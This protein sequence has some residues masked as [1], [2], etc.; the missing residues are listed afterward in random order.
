MP[1][2]YSSTILILYFRVFFISVYEKKHAEIIILM[3]Q[4][5]LLHIKVHVNA[6]E[7]LL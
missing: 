6:P 7:C 1:T 2:Y 5:L 4:K 3:H